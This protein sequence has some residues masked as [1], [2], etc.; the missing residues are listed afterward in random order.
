M[1]K[2]F[3]LLNGMELPSI[4]F[5]TWRATGEDA[6]Q[7]VSTAIESGYRLISTATGAKS[8]PT[9]GARWR[10]STRTDW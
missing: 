7:A 3:K 4:G 6:Q 5:G 8:M 9:P 2:N 10:R 1:K